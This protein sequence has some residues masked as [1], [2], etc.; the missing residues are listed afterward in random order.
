MR[1]EDEIERAIRNSAA[2]IEMEGFHIDEE[3]K[4]WCRQLMRN[5]I[6]MDEYI[7]R[8]KKQAGIDT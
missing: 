2:S 8:V 7:E 4:E 3:C 6:T 1:N 5:E